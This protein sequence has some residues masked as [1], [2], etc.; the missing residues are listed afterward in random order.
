MSYS[1]LLTV[2][3]SGCYTPVLRVSCRPR[4]LRG[5]IEMLRLKT[6]D[7]LGPYCLSKFHAEEAVF[8]MVAEDALI[9]VISPTLPVGPGDRL[10]TPPARMSVAFCRGEMPAYRDCRFNLCEFNSP[11]LGARAL[12]E[13]HHIE[14]RS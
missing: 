3:L 4:I 6:S 14:E 12:V 13:N 1:P 10:Q 11:S 8:R 5:A 7:M 2:V 9:I